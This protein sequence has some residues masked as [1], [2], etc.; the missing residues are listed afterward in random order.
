MSN[1]ERPLRRV[2]ALLRRVAL[3][4]ACIIAGAV[5]GAVGQHFSGS[6]AWFLALPILV[7]V[8]WLFVANPTECLPHLERPPHHESGRQ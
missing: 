3:L 5:I 1:G 4:G 2:P 7:A 8:A 6:S